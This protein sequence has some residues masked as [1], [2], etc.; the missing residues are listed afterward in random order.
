MKKRIL[1]FANYFPP[2][3]SAASI[4]E[5]KIV[6]L[7]NEFGYK[8]IVLCPKEI[9]ISKQ[10]KKKKTN[11]ILKNLNVHYSSSTF[12]YPLSFIFSHFEN[13]LYYLIKIKK[14]FEPDLIFS[15]YHPHHY[16]SVAGSYISKILNVPHIIRSHDLFIMDEFFDSKLFQIYNHIIYPPVYKSIYKSNI[17]YVTTSEM[18]DYLLKIIKSKNTEIKI[19]HNGVDTNKFYPYKSKDQEILKQ[20]YGCENIILFTGLIIKKFGF[21]NFLH[22]LPYILKENRETHFIFIGYGPDL[23]YTLNFIKKE[24]LKEK[25]HY[26]GLKSHDYIPFYINNSDIGIG[27]FTK[28]LFV[29]YCMP[30]KCIEYMACSKC[31]ITTPISKDVIYNNDVGIVIKKDFSKEEFSNKLIMLIED[32]DLR[33]KLGENGLIK[34]RNKFDWKIVINSIIKDI[35]NLF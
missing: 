1:Y 19:S 13:L 29:Q 2:I 6:N 9:T 7:F 16:A 14:K 32:K 33:R 3:Q 34:V 20:Y 30:T 27:R 21:L 17:F 11:Y 12:K 10:L 28:S 31:F 24:G 25:V 23:K 26:L 35:L 4:I 22:S 8:I 18:Q 5:N 15:Q